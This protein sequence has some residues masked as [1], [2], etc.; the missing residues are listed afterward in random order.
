MNNTMVI[1]KLF[2]IFADMTGF[3]KYKPSTESFKVQLENEVRC[4]NVTRNEQH[5]VLALLGIEKASTIKIEDDPRLFNILNIL[6]LGTSM[7]MTISEMYNYINNEFKLGRINS[8]NRELLLEAFNIRYKD[9]KETEEKLDSGVK[10]YTLDEI[11]EHGWT[12]VIYNG[13]DRRLENAQQFWSREMRYSLMMQDPWVVKNIKDGNYEI[14]GEGKTIRVR[15]YYDREHTPMEKVTLS[16]TINV[17]I[18]PMEITQA[19]KV[20]QYVNKYND[21]LWFGSNIDKDNKIKLN[22][23]KTKRIEEAKK[24]GNIFKLFKR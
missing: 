18:H 11:R 10:Y 19:E 24:T 15:Q 23:D 8:Y 2:Y 5:I 12:I 13:K 21:H 20:L 14:I 17:Q 4:G 3:S 9:I 22:I 1:A 6:E 7:N 16:K